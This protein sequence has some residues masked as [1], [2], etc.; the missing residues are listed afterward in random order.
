MNEQDREAVA[1]VL[2][3][4]LQEVSPE[5]VQFSRF[6]VDQYCN[7]RENG[8]FPHEGV[9][10]DVEG[11]YGDMETISLGWALVAAICG[12]VGLGAFDGLKEFSRDI[13]RKLLEPY[14]DYIVEN[15][16]KLLPSVRRSQGDEAAK[17]LLD[18][19]NNLSERADKD[20]PK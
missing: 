6:L 2:K 7:V 18:W 14:K 16:K 8:D 5:E 12:S 17:R 3:V 20:K 15:L 4:I 9:T 13:V 10:H 11:G 19:S 1:G